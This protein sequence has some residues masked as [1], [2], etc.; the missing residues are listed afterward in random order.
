[1]KQRLFNFKLQIAW[2]AVL[3]CLSNISL[4]QLG[5]KG[6]SPEFSLQQ[7]IDYAVQ[8]QLSM[9]NAKLNEAIAKAKVAEVTGVGLPQINGSVQVST[10]DPL[11]RM[12]FDAKSPLIGLMLPPGTHAPDQKVFGVDNIFQLKN[13][14]DASL[15]VTQLIF[16]NSYLVGLQ[17]AKTY[18]E[19]AS[20][21]TEQ[22]KIGVIEAVTKAYYSVLIN[23]ERVKLFNGNIA[24]LDSLLKQTTAL[25]KNGMVENI[26][27]NRIQVSYNNLVTEK[28]KFENIILLSRALLKYQMNYPLDSTIVLSESL[29]KVTLNTKDL[30][31]APNY[32]NRIEYSLLNTQKRLQEL[33]LKNS[34][35]SYF[36]TLAAFA[37]V[38]EFSQSPKFDYF[39]DQNLWYGYA[40]FGLSLNIPI[41]DGLAKQ[42]KIKQAKLNLKMVE[43]S[44]E[45]LESSIYLQIK[46]A[47]IT[48]KN[49]LST[50]ELQ[51]K[52]IDLANEVAR[53]SKI[54]YQQ[55]VGSGLEL[56][57]A[58]NALLEAQTNYFN[59][60]YD[61]LISKVDY[62]K[63]IGIIK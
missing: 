4:A 41:F 38:G 52:N 15:S 57:T 33:N 23:E 32:E 27:V 63:A 43:N 46:S 53:V 11:R 49:S 8:H 1:M 5:S 20:K 26:D 25:Y 58:E 50:L 34:R 51:K 17:A 60:F 62:D 30:V 21:Q 2:V 13:G 3:G 59:A 12:F 24:R 18:R 44:M 29:N 54:K 22:T 14:G 45:S 7:A 61:A 40:M 39:T 56:T 35:S 37:N 42:Y 31:Q 55:G 16:S 9:E 36:P 28:G 19:L 48:L 6:I 10:N 47:D